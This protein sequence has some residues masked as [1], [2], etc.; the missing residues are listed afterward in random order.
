MLRPPSDATHRLHRGARRAWA[1]LS[2][3]CCRAPS[4]LP[5]Q[6]RAP[7]WCA[8]TWN[9]CAALCECCFSQ[10]STPSQRRK[11]AG[12]RPLIP[13]HWKSQW[14]NWWKSTTASEATS[15]T[16]AVTT[17]CDAS[18]IL[19]EN[20][21]AEALPR[22]RAA[23]GFEHQL[24]LGLAVC[25]AD[26]CRLVLAWRQPD[27]GLQHSAVEARKGLAVGCAGR[28]KVRYWAG[29]E[30]PGEH[31][32]HAV[33]GQRNSGLTRQLCDSLRNAA[34]GAFE[35][36]IDF[37]LVLYEVGEGGNSGGHRQRI[38][39]QRSGLVDQAERRQLVHHVGASAEGPAGQAAAQDLAQ[40]GEVGSDAVELLCAAEREA[41]AGHHLVENQQR[42]L[43]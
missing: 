22:Q 12:S 17:F 27:S 3:P 31:R 32:A 16:K 37:G 25:R 35:L 15:S 5:R 7:R 20:R 13:S 24:D 8:R 19:R 28:G 23:R 9:I 34:G 41:E 18:S 39:A 1:T 6:S 2:R 4:S 42:A 36:R 11:R 10:T 38:S 40:R 26:K 21:C 43:F 30:E 14:K 33:G 29:S